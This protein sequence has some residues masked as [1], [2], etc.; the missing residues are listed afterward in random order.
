MD[1][2]YNFISRLSDPRNETS[3]RETAPFLSAVIDVEKEDELRTFWALI[4]PEH[5]FP[6]AR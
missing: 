2:A 3:P 6:G 1:L 5:R 4:A